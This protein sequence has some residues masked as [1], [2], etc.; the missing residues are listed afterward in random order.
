MA[1]G[2]NRPGKGRAA[3]DFFGRQEDAKRAARSLVVMYVLS[4]ITVVA[5]LLG[6]LCLIRAGVVHALRLDE[7]QGIALYPQVTTLCVIGGGLVALMLG[8]TL[9][10]IYTLS[11]GG[12]VV[13][14]DIGAI[15]IDPDTTD[16]YHRRLINVAQEMAIAASVPMPDLYLLQRES[17]I[18]SLVAG[19]GPGDAA[20]CVTRGCLDRLDRDE[21][22]GI[23]AHEFSHIVHGDMRLNIH[24]SGLFAGIFVL[25]TWG[26]ALMVWG[27]VRKNGLFAVMGG[28]AMFM[29]G[30]IGY[31]IGRLTQAFISR[32]REYLADAAAIQF[33]RQQRGLTG[34]LKKTLALKE[35]SRISEFD[36]TEIAH[37]LFGEGRKHNALLAAHPTVPARIEALGSHYDEREILRIIQAWEAPDPQTP[38]SS[39]APA[40][41][42]TVPPAGP[43]PA[44]VVTAAPV[45]AAGAAIP[46]MPAV[47]QVGDA[48]L[49]HAARCLQSLPEAW[50]K[51]AQGD[52]DVTVMVLAM[53]VSA[54]NRVDQLQRI[55]ARYD[56][57]R[58]MQVFAL[59]KDGGVL[60]IQA[61]MPLLALALPSLRKM[62]PYR[63]GML[64]QALHEWSH[65]DGRVDLHEYCLVHLFRMYVREITQ[66]GAR[67]LMGA[68][69]L[70][71]CRV[72][73]GLLCALVA[74]EGGASDDRARSLWQAVMDRAIPG[75]GLTYTVPSAWQTTLDS[76]L[77]VL[78]ELRPEH[79]KIVVSSLSAI[80]LVDRK[81]TL[82]EAELL[83]LVCAC[84]HCPLPPFIDT[85]TI[86]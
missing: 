30:S 71:D 17:G 46:A 85:A 53:T 8:V 28:F 45:P 6:P 72:Q 1:T 68:A 23:V 44:P 41:P 84:I 60:P 50:L 47:G 48:A 73:F 3:T 34:A 80:I 83:R 4:V 9:F 67:R 5:M 82:A 32:S 15:P 49:A 59:L 74:R 35:G 36:P 51:A 81:V 25:S 42:A 54:D 79:K 61:R 40:A 10:R 76:Q 86:A 39:S 24:L 12:Y 31:V 27:A 7:Y 55:E 63:L 43:V 18:N 57:G 14:R 66:P 64:Q 19:H 16:P 38:T 77:A 13:M 75:H 78:D 2:S 29:V 62:D 26:R 11:D 22:Q 70:F 33:T 37:M 58:R 52:G 20:L 65:A 56:R 69:R 21:L